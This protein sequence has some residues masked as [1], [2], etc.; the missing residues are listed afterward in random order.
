MN[1]E[2]RL[3]GLEEDEKIA[4]Q[5][6]SALF[7]ESSTLFHRSEVEPS[8]LKSWW[9]YR[10]ALR[11]QRQGIKYDRMRSNYLMTRLALR[12]EMIDEMQGSA[13]ALGYSLRLEVMITSV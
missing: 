4:S 7:A 9:Y 3:K 13:R 11:V 10:K 12:K 6:A 2:E 8:E 5:K 1:Y